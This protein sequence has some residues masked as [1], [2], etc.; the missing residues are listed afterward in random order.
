M[1][2]AKNSHGG[3]RKN[4]GRKTERHDI[5][6]KKQSVSYDDRTKE[7]LKVLGRGNESLGIRFAARVA[8]DLYQDDKLELP[9]VRT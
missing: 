6:V 3:S 5:K 7:L 1:N 8:Y 4:A 2:E 9:Q